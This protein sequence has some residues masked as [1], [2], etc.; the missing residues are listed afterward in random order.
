MKQLF[1]TKYVSF[2]AIGLMAAMSLGSCS[3]DD[4]PNVPPTGTT[5]AKITMGVTGL[6]Q[7]KQSATDVNKDNSNLQ[8]IENIVLVPMVGNTWQNAIDLGSFDISAAAHSGTNY[9]QTYNAV[10]INRGVNKFRVY[11]GEAAKVAAPITAATKFQL[12]GSSTVGT[13]TVYEP[14]GLYYYVETEEASSTGTQKVT[15]EGPESARQDAVA[16]NTE[17]I[18]ITGVRYGVGLLT[19]R[20]SVDPDVVYVDAT[21]AVANPVTT[22]D[23]TGTLTLEGVFVGSQPE[24]VDAQFDPMDAAGKTRIV[25]DESI[26][27]STIEEKEDASQVTTVNNYTTLFQTMP[28]EEASVVLKLTSDVDIWAKDSENG[29]TYTKVA[30]GTAFYVKAV[31]APNNAEAGNS[32]GQ[33]CLFQKYYETKANL[34]INSLANATTDLPDITPTDVNLDVTVDVSWEEGFVFNETI[35]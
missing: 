8:D 15:I 11:G 16:E 20:V 5:L 28:G 2:M 35:D 25:K 21:G 9:T 14:A 4:E 29:T 1:T 27:S 22:A 31:L 32:N 33:T 30:A 6:P 19:T 12:G 13:T 24:M 23:F 18:A 3:N 26:A 10:A 34:K 17:H 7:T